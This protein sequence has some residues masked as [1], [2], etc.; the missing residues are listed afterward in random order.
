MEL[1]EHYSVLLSGSQ[2]S[3]QLSG[4]TDVMHVLCDIHTYVVPLL[5]KPAGL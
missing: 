3:P 5:E 2:R 1:I 4:K